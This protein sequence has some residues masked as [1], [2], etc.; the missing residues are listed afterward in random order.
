M[1]LWYVSSTGERPRKN[2]AGV[3]RERS[4]VTAMHAQPDYPNW[5]AR[6]IDLSFVFWL[7]WKREGP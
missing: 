5:Y 3:V 1:D 2:V 7:I 4:A 6:W